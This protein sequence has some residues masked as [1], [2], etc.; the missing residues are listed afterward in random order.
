MQDKAKKIKNR[1]NYFAF[2]IKELSGLV[3]TGQNW[4]RAKTTC[5]FHDDKHAD[6]LHVNILNG[7]Y[8]CFACGAKGDVFKFLMEK[9]NLTFKES[10]KRLESEVC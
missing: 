10:L 7:S 3:R 4:Y 1:I 6:S 5:P 9:Y 8:H 2:Y